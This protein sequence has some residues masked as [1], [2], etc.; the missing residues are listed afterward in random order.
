MPSPL[1]S[2]EVVTVLTLLPC[3]IEQLINELMALNFHNIYSL[4]MHCVLGTD[5][6]KYS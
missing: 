4:Y 3:A 6:I 2:N 1:Y 5:E